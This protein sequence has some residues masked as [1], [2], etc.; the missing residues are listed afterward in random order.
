MTYTI[1]PTVSNPALPLT[2]FTLEDSGLTA[3]YGKG[4]QR[5]VTLPDGWYSID[6]LTL[7]KPLHE[8]G[9]DQRHRQQDL[10]DRR[11]QSTCLDFNEETKDYE[12]VGTSITVSLDNV[13]PGGMSVDLADGTEAFTITWS[14]PNLEKEDTG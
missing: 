3:Q 6:S 8:T 4:N 14:S 1:T 11:R 9:H 5:S 2:G 7:Q 12:Q 10:P 13:A